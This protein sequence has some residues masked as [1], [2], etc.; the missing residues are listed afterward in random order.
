MAGCQSQGQLLANEDNNAT[1]TAV[2][3]G[4]FELDCP[5]AA[6]SVLSSKLLQPVLWGGEGRVETP[7]GV[8]GC[9][10]RSVY[11]VICALDS[12][13]CFAGRRPAAIPG[14]PSDGAAAAPDMAVPDCAARGRRL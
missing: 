6:G 14:S 4:Q 8:S 5:S 11:V 9:G 12:S 1:E 7:A 3:R 10:K 2:R 13:E